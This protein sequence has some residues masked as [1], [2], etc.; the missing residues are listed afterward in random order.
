[1]CSSASDFAFF[2]TLRFR[3]PEREIAA[4]E[5]AGCKALHLDVMDGVFVPNI[6]YGMT[7]VRAA[8]QCTDLPLDVHLMIVNPEKYI[9]E[10][11]DAGADVLTIH[12]E[13][14]K[15]PRQLLEQIREL[16]V[17]SGIAI[18]PGT[19]VDQIEDCV[20]VADLVLAMSVEPG[21]GGQSFN[22]SVLEK[23]PK[24]REKFGPE[25]LLQIDGGINLETAASAAA[26]GIDLFVTGSAIFRTKDY[27][28][29][30][31]RLNL[32]FGAINETYLS[33]LD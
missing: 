18:N 31:A 6:T 17:V 25:V 9:E 14:T 7:I 10:F 20:G 24:L 28:S 30:L 32:E 15:K 1:M 23:F 4:V 5:T 3:K 11:R 12:A 2:A 19:S 33:Q 22:E 29:A 26:A 16:D 13:A 8:R 27:A 21:F